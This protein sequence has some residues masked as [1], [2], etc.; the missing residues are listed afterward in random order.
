MVVET[1]NADIIATLILLKQEIEEE[2]GHAMKLTVV[3]GTEAHLLA[4]ELAAADVGVVLVPP[5]AFV[6]AMRA[7]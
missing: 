6:S 7:V 3:G 2:T 4:S 5:R 1:H